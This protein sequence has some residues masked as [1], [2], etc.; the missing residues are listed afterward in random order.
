MPFVIRCLFLFL[1][2]NYGLFLNTAVRFHYISSILLI[3]FGSFLSFIRLLAFFVL[4][5]LYGNVR[6][7]VLISIHCSTIPSN[8]TLIGFS[9]IIGPG[10]G[11][12]KDDM[13][14]CGC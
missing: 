8:N 9:G 6:V 5:A 11:R 10:R 14:R 2:Y 7:R 1:Y 3:L 12:R 4:F 13:M